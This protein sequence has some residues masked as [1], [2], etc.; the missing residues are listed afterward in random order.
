MVL[1]APP[2]GLAPCDVPILTYAQGNATMFSQQE[3]A[4]S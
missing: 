1:V 4:L 3:T 2:F